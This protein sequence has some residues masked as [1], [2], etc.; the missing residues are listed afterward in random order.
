MPDKKDNS[1][2]NKP[3]KAEPKPDFLYDPDEHQAKSSETSLASELDP[4][5]NTKDSNMENPKKDP[6][7]KAKR[8]KK[9]K[10]GIFLVLIFLLVIMIIIVMK[11]MSLLRTYS[12]V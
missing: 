3:S 11:N 9:I 7:K 6:L 2:K 12:M 4:M 8:K 1:P 5:N 10:K